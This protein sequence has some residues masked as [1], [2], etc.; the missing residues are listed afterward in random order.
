MASTKFDVH[1]EITDRIIAAIESA[2]AFQLPWSRS[3][4]GN[5]AR[6]VNVA[7]GKPYNGVNVLGL[8]SSAMVSGF[9]SSLWG[10]Y[11]QWQQAGGQVRKGE[12]ASPVVFYKTIEVS[13]SDEDDEPGERLFAR[14]SFVFNRAQVDELAEELEAGQACF[15]PI[16]HADRFV[17]AVGAHIEEGGDRAC[18]IPSLDKIVMPERSRFIR[19]DT[20]S[21]AHGYYATLL[22]ELVHWTSPKSRLDRSLSGRFGS[23]AYAIEELIAE[24]GAAF[25]CADLA[26]AAEPRADHAAYIKSWLTVLKADKKAI[27]TAASKASEAANWLMTKGS[28]A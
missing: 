17:A 20:A 6:P 7:S 21:A 27:F 22:H 19:T 14:A 4:T 5:I 25:L 8:W 24:L 28:T 1:Q 9:S 13:S 26:I 10:T 23:E 15:D 11:R 12:K 16:E 3:G 18:Y 2:G